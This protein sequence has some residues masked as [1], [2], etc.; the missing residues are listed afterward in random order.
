MLL[1]VGGDDLPERRRQEG[2][3]LQ[4][5]V[6]A[7]EQHPDDRRVRRRPADAFALQQRD[8][9]P[10]VVAG[11]RLGEVLLGAQVGERERLAVGEVGQLTARLL[12][13]AVGPAVAVEL[14]DLPRGPEHQRRVAGRVGGDEVGAQAVEDGRRHLRGDGA[15]PDQLVQ[16]PLVGV[17]TG[18]DARRQ[19]GGARR[20][21]RLVRL[22]GTLGLGLE[23]PRPV[24]RVALPELLGDD[25]AQLGE[26]SVGEVDAVGPHVG[27]EPDLAF[28][29]EVDALVQL[30]GDLHRPRRREPQAVAGLDLQRRGRERRLGTLLG[31]PPGRGGDGPGTDLAGAPLHPVRGGGVGDHEIAVGGGLAGVLGEP[32]GR[33]EATAVDAVQPGFQARRLA[34]ERPVDGPVLLGDEAADLV[35]TVADQPQRDR[36]HPAGGDAAGDVAPQRR[37]QPVADDPVDRAA[38]LLGVDEVRVDRAGTGE[39]GQDRVA[40]DLGEH[41][42]VVRGR[43]DAGDLGDVPGDRLTLTVQ[44]GGEKHPLGV[45]GCLLDRAD[46]LGRC[47][48][49]LVAQMHLVA[50]D[51]DGEVA[52]R[53]VADVPDRGQDPVVRAQVLLDG[54]RLGR[55]L[56]DDEVLSHG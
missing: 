50:A 8:E 1:E 23:H 56:D 54:L 39:R 14:H 33:H 37:R 7:V 26:R 19:A 47:L 15:A 45:L 11:R 43:V 29:P 2:A 20:A 12:A 30:L 4:A 34:G 36:L 21:D 6:L 18:G 51:L 46:D 31:L 17:E 38:G 41:D 27:D 40:G 42:P 49:D 25:A 48:G 3:P 55:R 28:G 35:L 44:V 32:L 53:Q 22:L 9:R 52:A 24:Q 13:L 5:H 10:L 16:R